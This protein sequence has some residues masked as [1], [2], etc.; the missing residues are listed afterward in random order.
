MQTIIVA[1]KGFAKIHI[2]KLDKIQK[3]IQDKKDKEVKAV[4]SIA[5]S[6]EFLQQAKLH[7]GLKLL[8]PWAT[9]A[10]CPK[11]RWKVERDW[12]VVAQRRC[13]LRKE[14]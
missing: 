7:N 6:K 5:E 10:G 14:L 2:A 13:W 1:N 9:I 8:I 11:C 4:Q 12:H 3:Q